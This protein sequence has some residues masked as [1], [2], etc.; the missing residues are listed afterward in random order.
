[1]ETSTRRLNQLVALCGL[2]AMS[3]LAACSS[4]NGGSSGGTG[5]ASV[6]GGIT[7]HGGSSASGGSTA[8]GGSSISG[9]STA[10]GGKATGGTTGSGGSS[11]GPVTLFA[12]DSGDQGW[13]Y[14]SYQ[15]TDST[16]GANI[17]PFNAFV[18]GILSGGDLDGG[19]A[20]PTL[21]FDSSTGDPAGSLKAQVTFT[22]FDQQVNPNINWGANA[23]QDWT[24]KVV[25]VRIKVDPFPAD[26][27][28]FG[29]ITLFAQD[30]TYAGQY[31]SS[32][33]PTDNQWHTY[34]LD[35]NGTTVDASKII[36]FTVQFAAAWMTPS[37]AGVAS[38][39]PIQLTAYIDTITVL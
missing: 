8:S 11:A 33:F 31:Q 30:S 29:N 21:A 16:S 15:A 34:T 22:G 2:G 25:S 36:Q 32:P 35:M 38:F 24:N 27:T 37:D 7:G 17:P 4:D 3:I 28:N 26:A 13:V 1:V 19:V 5:G 9:G 14:N 6:T 18:S 39:A 23:L 20:L 10:T 12:F